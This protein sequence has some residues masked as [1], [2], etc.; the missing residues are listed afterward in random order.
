MI[1]DYDDLEIYCRMLGH[2]LTFSYCRSTE[3]STPCRRI[4]DC[5]FQRIPVRQFAEEH[6]SDEILQQI[7][8]PPRDKMLTI[9]ELIEQA[10][11]K[12]EA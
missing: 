4:I 11:N 3:G 1:R 6:F 12:R 7:S 2:P 8:S 10:K 5:W 9:L